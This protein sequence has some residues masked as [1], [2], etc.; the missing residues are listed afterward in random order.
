MIRLSNV[1]MRYPT[2][3]GLVSVFRDVN[4][5]IEPGQKW[6]ILGCNGAGKSTLVRL[7]GGAERPTSGRIE[8]SMSVSWPLAFSGGFQGSLTGL[9]NLR[10]ICRVYGV[11]AR[12][13]VEFVE[14]FSELGR[15]LREP[16]KTYSAGMRARLAFALSMVIDFDCFLIDEVVA[17]GDQR[18]AEKC[19][20]EL[21]VRR[22]HHAMVLVSHNK[23]FI[24]QHCD[25][26]AV[27]QGGELHH[28]ADLASAFEFYER[29]Q[30]P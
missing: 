11:E 1:G 13:R 8:R 25:H 20:Y 10:F 19:N 29:Y 24:Q 9:D 22:R 26:A 2:S 15:Y 23:G 7:I 6:G 21:F 17:V 14:E 3:H 12:D 28:F 18:F 27:M 16:V 30:H 5:Q 4:L